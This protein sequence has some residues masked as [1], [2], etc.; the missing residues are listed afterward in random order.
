MAF[1][2]SWKWKSCCIWTAKPAIEAYG[3]E[4]FYQKM[5]GKR[6]EVSA[7][8]GGYVRPG[9]V[10]G[11]YEGPLRKPT[12]I[13]TSSP[14]WWSLKEIWKKDLLYKGFK[15]VPYCP[16]C[17]TAL[18]SHEVAQG[19]KEV[20]DTSAFV[21]FSGQGAKEHLHPRLDDHTLDLAQ[22]RG[23]VRKRQGNLCGL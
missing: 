6:L 7:G 5:Q 1:L 12:M 4:P 13:P 8:V 20:S 10:L 23:A 19:Y 3:I 16:R 2:L 18:S 9:R 22:Q 15:V 11:G 21:R 14:F 17:G